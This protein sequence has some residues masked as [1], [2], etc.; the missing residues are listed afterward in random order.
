[1]REK[2]YLQGARPA[3]TLQGVRWQIVE[4]EREIADVIETGEAEEMGVLMRTLEAVKHEV[5]RL[6]NQEALIEGLRV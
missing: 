1:M 4:L 6:E 5:D 2:A 3:E